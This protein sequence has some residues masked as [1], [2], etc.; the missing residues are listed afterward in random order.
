MNWKHF[1]CQPKSRHQSYHPQTCI[2][3]FGWLLLLQTI[4]QWLSEEFQLQVEYPLSAPIQC[5]YPQIWAK[6]L[7][8]R[9]VWHRDSYPKGSVD[10]IQKLLM[11]KGLMSQ[12]SLF[13]AKEAICVLSSLFSTLYLRIDSYWWHYIEFSCDRLPAPF[14]RDDAFDTISSSIL[15]K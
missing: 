4:I 3:Y 12:L 14:V 7:P 2:T 8:H 11:W 15:S 5:T 1:W 6:P 13:L 9:S 10:M